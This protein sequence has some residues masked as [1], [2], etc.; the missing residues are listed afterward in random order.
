MDRK[1]AS[2]ISIKFSDMF[3]L[4][5]QFIGWISSTREISSLGYRVAFGSKCLGVGRAYTLVQ[6]NHMYLEGFIVN[7]VVIVS[8]LVG[9]SQP[10]CEVARLDSR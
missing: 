5:V 9:K 10:R 2:I 1:T 4:D 8:I 7:G 6:L 3:K